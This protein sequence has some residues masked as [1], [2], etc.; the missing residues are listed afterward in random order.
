ML[1]PLGRYDEALAQ[2]G[3]LLSTADLSD[4]ERSWTMMVEGFVLFNANRLDSADARFVRVTDLGYVHDNPRLIAAAAWGRALVA[5]R[6][7]DLPAT[8]RWIGSAENT[9][10]GEA[11][12]ML[13]V[14]FL[15]DMATVLGGLG[16]L[17]LATTYL[18]GPRS[19]NPVFPGQVASTAFVLDARKGLA[20]R[21]RATGWPRP[22]RRR[23]GGSSSSRPRRG[24]TR[25]PGDWPGGWV[26]RR[27][28]SSWLSASARRRLSAR[29][30]HAELQV[31]L[32]RL[33]SRARRT[34]ATRR[35]SRPP[36]A[37][38]RRLVVIGEPISVHDG[39]TVD[40]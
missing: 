5:S 12:D 26:T 33:P 2:V 40:A 11:D 23:G 24:P 9:A 15:C 17:D 14:P 13:G 7:G 30:H 16:E 31:A 21:P 34:A 3:Q 37:P 19:A 25:R 32:Q 28:T 38:A 18:A 36:T 22:C 20:R 35:R 4:A 6:R 27:A 10:L 1:A 29:P 39:D 8:L